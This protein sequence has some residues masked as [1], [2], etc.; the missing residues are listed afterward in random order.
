M[1]TLK[2]IIDIA[3]DMIDLDVKRDEMFKWM[4]DAF[5]CNW[6]LPEPMSQFEHIRK[7]VSTDP[8]VALRA[9]TWVL[10]ANEPNYKINPMS[11]EPD[12][13][14]WANTVEQTIR[15]EFYQ[16]S[17]RRPA[18]IRSDFVSSALSFDEIDVE[19][20][21]LP[22][23]EKAVAQFGGTASRAKAIKRYGDFVIIP[24]NPQ[25]VHSF[26]SD[27][28]L[29]Q[30][31]SMNVQSVKK[32]KAFWGDKAKKLGDDDEV[33]VTVFDYWDGDIRTVFANVSGRPDEDSIVIIEPEKHGLPFI[34]WVCK[35]GGTSL[36][37]DPEFQR[38]PMLF[39]IYRARQWATTNIMQTMAYS[40]A[41]AHA[42][43]PKMN[44]DGPGS[45]K[46]EIDHTNPDG[47][48][49]THGQNI[50]MLPAMPIDTGMIELSNFLAQAM[51]KSTIPE[52][53]QGIMPPSGMAYASMNLATQSALNVIKPQKELTEIALAEV[54]ETMLLW[55]EH[56]GV[57]LKAWG[58][59]KE[60]W[61]EPYEVKSGDIDP[62]RLRIDV[63]LR[64]DLPVD[65]M[66]QITGARTLVAELGWSKAAVAKDLGMEDW[67]GMQR[68][69]IDETLMEAHVRNRQMREEGK[70]QLELQ[71][72]TMAIQAKIQMAM[73]QGQQGA[74]GGGGPAGPPG[75][76]APGG[77]PAG[78]QQGMEAQY[79]EQ[80][81]AATS[82]QT[83]GGE[84]LPGMNPAA[85][86]PPPAMAEPGAA[87]YERKRGRP[88]K[89]G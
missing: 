49:A 71:A 37:E 60:D 54:G 46:V 78:P 52:V 45:D 88:R 18:Q 84:G 3:E 50:K 48:V 81:P 21:F 44:I 26:H 85:G 39:P 38:I 35:I 1:K 66:Q 8:Y 17:R 73:Q 2:D 24:H 6:D 22:Y 75:G 42:M 68:E 14:S 57:N 55:S 31:L 9:G 20:M 11:S 72:Q 10:A 5:R 4:V 62:K 7:I 65:R 56:S 25:T 33:E 53:L 40:E 51:K 83:P 58:V 15:W 28:G 19:V 32:A 61:G 27:Y 70:I 87:T 63:E 74:Q 64:P 29:E 16:A 13:K 43:S 36:Y 30:V 79:Q 77:Q 47:I 41:I 69:K 89:S 67:E 80:P 23:Q 59:R 76:G 12:A 82:V 34:P 86:E